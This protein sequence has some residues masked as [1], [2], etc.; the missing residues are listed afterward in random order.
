MLAITLGVALSGCS[1][2]AKQ[3]DITTENPL[4]TETGIMI[5]AAKCQLVVNDRNIDLDSRKVDLKT[6]NNKTV[7]VTGEY[8][9]T[10]LFVDEA[11]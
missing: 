8:S 7:T 6:F 3:A 11:R 5:C 1:L 10:T 9:G 2:V 4:K